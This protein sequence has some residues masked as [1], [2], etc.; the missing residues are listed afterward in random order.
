MKTILSIIMI[1][2]SI[3]GFIL[4]IIPTYNDAKVIDQQKVDYLEL[5]ANARQLEERRDKLLQLYS[6]IS[7]SDMER[8]DK[9]LPANPDNVKLILEIDG[10]ARSQGLSLQNVK[11]KESEE[12]T[13]NQP[14]ARNNQRSNP[15]IGTLTLEFATVGPYPGYVNFIGSLEKNLRIMNVKKSSFIAPEDSANYQFQTSVETYWVK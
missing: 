2:A 5:L 4:Y 6:G 15:D 14:Q 8:L 13:A 12:N 9:I 11:I 3:G 1:L 10:L 7:P